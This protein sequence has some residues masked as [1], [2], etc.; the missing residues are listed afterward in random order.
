MAY[1]SD[2]RSYYAG[3]ASGGYGIYSPD[4]T[5]AVRAESPLPRYLAI[6]VVLLGLASYLLS[7]GPVFG[8]GSVLWCVRFA[9][10]AALVAAF[11]GLRRQTSFDVVVAVLAAAGFL[12]ALATVIV[13]PETNPPGWA[14]T[15]IVVVNGLQM[16]C[17]IAVLALR[18]GAVSDTASQSQYDAYADYYAQAA[19]YGHYAQQAEQPEDLHRSAAGHAQHQVAGTQAGRA[20]AA[21]AGNYADYIGSHGSEPTAMVDRSS[22]PPR[23]QTA[24]PGPHAGLPSFGQTQGSAPDHGERGGPGSRPSTSH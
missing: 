7:F 16:A 20:S 10:G 17:A 14:L 4:F 5:G 22:G 2:N 11:A 6:A 9:V 18:S 12:D 15:A 24:P 13:A 8:D 21:Q 23:Q 3:E 19:Y 1:P